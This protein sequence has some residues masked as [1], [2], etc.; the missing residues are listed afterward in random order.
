MEC[1]EKI[2][3][4]LKRSEGQLRGIVKMVE[5]GRNCSEI[6]TQLMAARSSID[7][8]IALIV[9]ENIKQ[10]MNQDDEPLANEDLQEALALIMKTR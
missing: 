4:R 10:Q 7:K 6:A 3:N 8:V 9:T 5:E 1:D 2:I